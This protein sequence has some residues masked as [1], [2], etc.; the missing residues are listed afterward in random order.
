VDDLDAELA[1]LKA[2]NIEPGTGILDFHDRK[3]VFITGPEGV[4][5]DLSQWY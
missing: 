4:T 1:R 5:L 3:L 2:N